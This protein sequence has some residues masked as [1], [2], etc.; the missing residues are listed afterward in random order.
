MTPGT[1]H[2]LALAGALVAP[3][4]IVAAAGGPPAGPDGEPVRGRVTYQG[5][6]VHDAGILFGSVGTSRDGVV[7]GPIARDGSFELELPRGKYQISILPLSR[8]AWTR[9]D[10]PPRPDGQAAPG[11]L[12]S[13]GEEYVPRRFRFPTTSQLSVTIDDRA[14]RLEI[15]LK[16]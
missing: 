1:L 15:D 13:P 5:R 4:L 7:S 14:Y 12:T 16:D 9:A 10:R 3:G 8:E 6:P 11:T 2:S